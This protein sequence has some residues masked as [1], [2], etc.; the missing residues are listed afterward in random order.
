MTNKSKK[1]K[2]TEEEKLR[3]EQ[4]FRQVREQKLCQWYKQAHDEDPQI[5][6][7]AQARLQLQIWLRE[8]R[9]E[10][11]TRK[12]ERDACKVD[13][14]TE[15][16]ATARA[17]LKNAQCA[18]AMHMKMSIQGI[19]A[20]T[21]GKARQRWL[22]KAYTLEELL[23]DFDLDKRTEFGVSRD[24]TLEAV[25]P[26][27]QEPEALVERTLDDK[28]EL[29][30][31]RPEIQDAG[32]ILQSDND[33]DRLDQSVPDPT[34][35]WSQHALHMQKRY[36][37][38][39]TPDFAVETKLAFQKKLFDRHVDRESQMRKAAESTAELD[40]STQ[41]TLREGISTTWNAVLV[42]TTFSEHSLWELTSPILW[43]HFEGGLSW[44]YPQWVPS[45]I[46]RIQTVSN[47]SYVY[48]DFGARTFSTQRLSIPATVSTRV[49]TFPAR[50]HQSDANIDIEMKFLTR[51]F[52][53]VSF[54]II[55]VIQ[56]D[57]GCRV[58]PVTLVEFT[59]AWMGPVE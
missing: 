1:P 34:A 21:A 37:L 50:C 47:A 36:R 22:E 55:N 46:M 10:I 19:P 41:R 48:F 20:S 24:S 43:R 32:M 59:G 9:K 42:T 31:A 14:D 51:G 17:K 3:L 8:K 38:V 15:G 7:D 29:D 39:N 56:P 13:G 23:G 27:E 54:P 53:K 40:L 33:P 12:Q 57:M 28:V 11:K 44:D 5:K 18:M 45:G 2:L 49:L 30:D 4:C 25:G 26:E 6:A 58:L 16:W 52:V 35:I